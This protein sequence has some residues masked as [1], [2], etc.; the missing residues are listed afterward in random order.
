[1]VD[2]F[3]HTARR[4]IARFGQQAF[5]RPPKAARDPARPWLIEDSEAPDV[6]VTIALTEIDAELHD[7]DA[8]P[9]WSHTAYLAGCG[10]EVKTLHSL[11][12]QGVSHQILKVSRLAPGSQTI[13]WEL[14]IRT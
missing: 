10:V 12:V 8:V 13:Y 7:S 3:S 1:M 14:S 2:L 5:L 6:P 4:L 11:V 9:L